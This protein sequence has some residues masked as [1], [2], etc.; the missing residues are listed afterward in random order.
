MPQTHDRARD[1]DQQTRRDLNAAGIPGRSLLKLSGEALSGEGGRGI[2]SQRLTGI[3][4]ELARAGEQ[5]PTGLAVVVGGGNIVRG[6]TLAEAGVVDRASADH[7]GMLGTIIN[8]IALRDRLERLAVPAEVLS[9]AGVRGI[10]EQYTRRRGLELL[11]AGAIVIL[12]AGVGSP[13][14]TTDTGAA[15]RAVELRCERLLKATKVD[16]VYSADPKTDPDATRY[17]TLTYSEAIDRR[18]GVMDVG[19]IEMC[20]RQGVS[21]VVFDFA[22]PGSLARAAAGEPIGTTLTPG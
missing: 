14:F 1:D 9:A 2:D 13:F 12:A 19:A 8:A 4:R 3:A 10:A 21:L 15:L 20:Q 18:L 22:A 17:D 7:M 5:C 6:A 11:D 16:G